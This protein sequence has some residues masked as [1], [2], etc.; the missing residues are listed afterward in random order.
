MAEY[1]DHLLV[2]DNEAVCRDLLQDVADKQSGSPLIISP[3]NEEGKWHNAAFMDVGTTVSLQRFGRPEVVAPGFRI[4]IQALEVREDLWSIGKQN[5]EL[6]ADRT[7][8]CEGRRFV[9]RSQPGRALHSVLFEPAFVGSCYGERRDEEFRHFIEA[10]VAISANRGLAADAINLAAEVELSRKD[11]KSILS[12]LEKSRELITASN[13]IAEDEKHFLLTSF[14]AAVV[15]VRAHPYKIA[16]S[17]LVYLV[18]SPVY[19]AYCSAIESIAKP[20]FVR[21]IELIVEALFQGTA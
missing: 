7:A 4:L 14:E 17:V 12:A 20:H 1:F 2:F 19:A 16:V 18:G 9:V 6:I 10:L 5:C 21:L 3:E 13:T 15:Y 8:A 11:S